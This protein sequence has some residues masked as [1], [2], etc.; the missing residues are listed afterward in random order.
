MDSLETPDVAT[1]PDIIILD[2]TYVTRRIARALDADGWD[3]TERLVSGFLADRFWEVCNL[4]TRGPYCPFIIDIGYIKEV[5][6]AIWEMHVAIRD[7]FNWEVE[8]NLYTIGT[9]IYLVPP[10]VKHHAQQS[11]DCGVQTVRHASNVYFRKNDSGT[12]L[13]SHPTEHDQRETV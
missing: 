4:S 2:G 13:P 11:L 8:Y 1:K 5:D 10:G 7:A 3:V 6:K 12:A 9:S